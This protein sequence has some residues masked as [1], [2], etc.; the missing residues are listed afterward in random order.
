MSERARNGGRTRLLLVRH[1]ES[2]CNADGRWQGQANPPLSALG[3]Q[4]AVDAA[5]HVAPIDTVWSSDLARARRT[6]EIIAGARRVDV[7]VDPRLRERD[8][9][10]WQ[11]YTRAEIE[12][13]WPGYL[14]SDRRPAGYE[15]D[16]ELLAR[17]LHAIDEIGAVHDG[18]AVLVISHGGVV[19][20][21]ERHFGANLHGLLPNLGGRWLERGVDA[22]ADGWSLGDRVLLLEDVPV[23]T[24]E[25]I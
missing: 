23:T 5:V 10:E 17:V 8:A 11:G 20:T 4:Q 24:P 18:A 25:Q 6:A 15:T 14:E 13:L 9:G 22:G 7:C 3:E 16:D 12:E 2:T 1:G 21:L 19:R